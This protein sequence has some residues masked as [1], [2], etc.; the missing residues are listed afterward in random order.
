MAGFRV[1]MDFEWE[2]RPGDGSPCDH[3][4]D[5]IF[6]KMFVQVISMGP[7]KSETERKLCE[8]CY[9]NGD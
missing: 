4:K 2:E 9:N 1:T 5:P 8:S 6:L 7:E 3:C